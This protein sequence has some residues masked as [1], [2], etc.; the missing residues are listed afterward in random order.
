[1]SALASGGGRLLVIGCLSLVAFLG[2]GSCGSVMIL[3]TRFSMLDIEFQTA[4]NFIEHRA[5][6]IEHPVLPETSRIKSQTSDQNPATRAN[7]QSY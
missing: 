6:S 7:A 1:L 2:W 5:S 4:R 3:D